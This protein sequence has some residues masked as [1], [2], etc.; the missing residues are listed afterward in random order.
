M[1]DQDVGQFVSPGGFIFGLSGWVWGAQRPVSLTF[2]LNGTAMVSDQ[3]G[4]PI[5]GA[6]IDGKDVW[7]A[8]RPPQQD[9]PIAGHIVHNG[10]KAP[11]A[12]HL[13]VIEA[14]AH[15]RIDWQTL[16]HAGWPQLPYAE[17]KKIKS[18]P[19]WPFSADHDPA[20][21]AGAFCTCVTCSIR[22]P[23]IRKDAIRARHE[24]KE[25]REAEVRS[26]EAEAQAE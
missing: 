22:N 15:E 20:P 17:L 11:L 14:L 7:F 3:W 1:A 8:P 16:T 4:R 10:K 18:L 19:F 26:V 24:W 13:D 2:F 12:S 23:Q 5:K 6:N 9:D 21:T 25:A